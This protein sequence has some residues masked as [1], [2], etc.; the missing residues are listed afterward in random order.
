MKEIAQLLVAHD[1]V[2][3]NFDAPFTWTSGIKSPIYCDCRELTG[4]VEARASVVTHMIEKIKEL[5]LTP[6]AIAGTATAGI[7]WAAWVAGIMN[8]PMIYVRKK[9]KG[10]G[11]D[12]LIEGRF[13]QS[14]A[15]I[16]LVEDAF[17]TGNSSISAAAAIQNELGAKVPNIL[18][19]FTWNTPQFQKNNQTSGF[20]M[21]SLTTFAEIAEALVEAGKISPTQKESLERFHQDPPNWFKSENEETTEQQLF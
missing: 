20:S 2:K 12:K 1:I 9:T 18:G 8:V 19:I 10:H 6:D 16:V 17:S 14:N 15:N 11:A 3:T 5:G 13:N 4:L 21:S 7:S